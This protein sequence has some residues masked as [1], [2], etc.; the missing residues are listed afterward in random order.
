MMPKWTQVEPNLRQDG[1]KMCQDRPRW[2][3]D[4]PKMEPRW[5]QDGAKRAK[6]GQDEAKMVPRWS[7]DGAKMVPRGPR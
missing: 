3:Q 7:Q 2:G 1:A 5:G 4:G 6:I